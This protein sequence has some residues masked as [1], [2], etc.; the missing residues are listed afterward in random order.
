MEVIIAIKKGFADTPYP[1]SR[2]IDI[3]ATKYDDEGVY[4]YFVGSDQFDH[5]VKDLWYHSCALSFFTDAAFRYWI[6]AFMIAELENP[7]EA[8]II[9]E[10]IAFHLS[11]AQGAHDK[12]CQFSQSEIEALKLFLTTCV[13]NSDEIYAAVYQKALDKIAKA[14][15]NSAHQSTTAP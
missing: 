11:K 15:Q 1:G 8:D 9:G 3:S 14:E 13:D 5:D 6:P 10:S 2:R 12:I 4:E 7:V